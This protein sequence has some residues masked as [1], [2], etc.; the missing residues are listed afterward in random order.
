MSFCRNTQEVILNQS[1]KDAQDS[2]LHDSRVKC[3]DDDRSLL[4]KLQDA[5]VDNF[6][7]T[8]DAIKESKINS[9]IE[10]LYG[11]DS[12][13]EK[14]F[15]KLNSLLEA[16]PGIVDMIEEKAL[17]DIS[18]PIYKKK[19]RDSIIKDGSLNYSSLPKS[20]L[21]TLIGTAQEIIKNGYGQNLGRGVIGKL[22]VEHTTPRK[23]RKYD[24]TGAIAMMA[25]AVI[26]F[27]KKVSLHVTRFNNEDMFTKGKNARN[28]G[29]K[30]VM[31]NVINMRL[32]LSQDLKNKLQSEGR[33]IADS[34]LM[35]TFWRI[36]QGWM[37]YD[38]NTKRFM[39]NNNYGPV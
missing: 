37:Y 28:Y 12:D 29:M 31:S 16:Y 18:R 10:D 4:N 21:N 17:I 22:L 35:D 24:S 15:V 7:N 36:M 11:K 13:R 19:I 20:L 38:E 33:S 2:A 5:F 3:N 34:Y 1:Q 14:L 25:N 9:Q 30:D 27:T 8:G 32:M 26:D 6:Y 23:L 39:I